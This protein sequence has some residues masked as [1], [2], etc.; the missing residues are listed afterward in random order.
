MVS[1]ERRE[2]VLEM[3]S[4][5]SETVGR[6]KFGRNTLEKYLFNETRSLKGRALVFFAVVKAN[7]YGHGDYEVAKTALDAGA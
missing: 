6:S 3:K 1:I 2:M 4:I 7:A 5:S